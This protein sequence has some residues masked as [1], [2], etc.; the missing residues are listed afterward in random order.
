MS[1][2]QSWAWIPALS[3][4]N[5]EGQG[6]L[7][8]LAG[9]NPLVFRL[10]IIMKPSLSG[11]KQDC[12][13]WSVQSTGLTGTFVVVGGGMAVFIATWSLCSASL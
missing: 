12:Q 2:R 3:F 10:R 5:R 7:F 1:V 6:E 13:R 8:N 11:Y 9:F 4:S